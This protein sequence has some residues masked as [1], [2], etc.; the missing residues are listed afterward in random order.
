MQLIGI[1]GG[2]GCGKSFVMEQLAERYGAK[3]IL[4]DLVAHKLMERGKKSYREIVE[5]FGTGILQENGEINRLAL[6]SIVFQNEKELL[7][8]NK[9][10][11]PNVREEIIKEIAKVRQEGKVPFIALEA[12]L[13]LEEHYDELCDEVWFVDADDEVRIARLMEKRGYTREKCLDIM[14][15]Q[16]KRKQFQE[17]CQHVIHNNTTKEAVIE[18]LDQLTLSFC[19]FC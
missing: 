6:A 16:L 15:K 8:L 17:K 13:L 10:T 7:V 2:V 4:A 9:I 3:V 18:Q 19:N 5:H 12:A 1:T 14:E 11:H